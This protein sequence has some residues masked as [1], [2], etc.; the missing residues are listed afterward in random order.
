M[1]KDKIKEKVK[2]QFTDYLSL[3]GY[4]KTPERYKILDLIYS[5]SKH[6]DMEALYEEMNKQNFRVSRATLYNTMQLLLECKLVHKHQFGKNLSCYEKAFNNDFHY[7]LICTSCKSIQECKDMEIRELVNEK[8]I[9]KFTPSHYSL[10]V[11]GV[12]S[13]C[14]AKKKRKKKTEESEKINTKTTNLN[15][16]AVLNHRMLTKKNTKK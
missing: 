15:G 13:V 5:E 3:K 14:G 1:D 7:H 9:K 2:Q 10:Y 8:K 16:H 4:R 12:C 11:F 6:F